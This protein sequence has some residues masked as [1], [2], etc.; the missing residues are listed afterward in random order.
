MIFR[1]CVFGT[2]LRRNL[3]FGNFI[4]HNVSQAIIYTSLTVFYIY[5]YKLFIHLLKYNLNFTRNHLDAII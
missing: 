1:S 3:I 2:S 4:L 5:L